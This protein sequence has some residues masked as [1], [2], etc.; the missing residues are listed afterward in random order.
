MTA[1]T[2]TASALSKPE[3]RVGLKGRI[4]ETSGYQGGFP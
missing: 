4:W 3:I 1:R 2:D